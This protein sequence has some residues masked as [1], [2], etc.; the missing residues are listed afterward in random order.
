MNLRFSRVTAII[1]GEKKGAK[2]E[3]IGFIFLIL[4]NNVDHIK[5]L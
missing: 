4:S 3:F 2:H 5:I 1:K